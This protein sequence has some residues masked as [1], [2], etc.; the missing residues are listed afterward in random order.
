MSVFGLLCIGTL[1]FVLEK[2]DV[3]QETGRV[4]ES[5]FD[6]LMQVVRT[7]MIIQKCVI[8]IDL[9]SCIGHD[10]K[11]VNEGR[12]EIVDFEFANHISQVEFIL[13][14]CVCND[15]IGF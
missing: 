15:I 14:N 7:F 5:C 12:I 9:L 13:E 8:F 2:V 11:H 6:L 10:L 1:A 3:I 4:A